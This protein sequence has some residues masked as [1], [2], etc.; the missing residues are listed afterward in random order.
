MA[1]AAPENEPLLQD[2]PEEEEDDNASKQEWD[3]SHVVNIVLG[4]GIGS[5][6]EFYSFGLVA[7]FQTELESAYFPPSASGYESML[8]EFTLFGLAFVMRPFGSLIFGYIGDKF[9]RVFCLRLSLFTMVIPTVLFGCIPN[10]SDIG[11]AA[12]VIVFILRAMQGISVGGE[13]STALVYIYEEAPKGMKATLIGYVYAMSC[14]SYFALIVYDLYAASEDAVGGAAEWSWRFAFF[15]AFFVGLFG[16]YM[17]YIMPV[18]KAFEEM[19]ESGTIEENPLKSVFTTYYVEFF[20]L[21]LVYVSP[22]LIYYSNVVWIPIYLDS[23]I[24]SLTDPYSYD[25]QI[26][27]SGLSIIFFAISGLIADRVGLYKYFKITS[28]LCVIAVFACY[29]IIGLSSNVYVVSVFQVGISICFLGT[30][31]L[32]YWAMFWCP[33]ASIRNSLMAISYNLGMA[34]FVST[35]FD[36]ETYLADL[37]AY[38]GCLYAGLYV[39]AFML[40]SMGAIV[41]SENYHTWEVHLNNEDV[42]EEH[43]VQEEANEEHQDVSLA[44]AI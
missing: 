14:G 29:L 25:M 8:E 32:L 35:Q 11:I 22:A 41:W 26:V 3:T 10:Y 28:T 36:V 33:I 39:I 16:L 9:G 12:T 44:P 27:S 18:S 38:M 6:M 37:D 19:E 43:A 13:T 7:Y 42:R 20:V 5:L 21:F 31:A 34:L 40:A 24:A 17:R 23:S 15:S 1:S 4:A 30:P 2:A